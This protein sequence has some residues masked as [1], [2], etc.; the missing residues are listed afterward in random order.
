MKRIIGHLIIAAVL[1][2]AGATA[3]AQEAQTPTAPQPAQKPAE[4]ERVTQPDR[5]V[6]PLSNPAKPAK[7]EASVMRGS[8]TVKGYEGKEVIAEA[9][10][11]EKAIG[12]PDDLAYAYAYA[13]PGKKK[14]VASPKDVEEMQKELQAA[15]MDVEQ[16]KKDA[17]KNMALAKLA[18]PYPPGQEEKKERSH[19]GMKLVTAALT[20]L[21][22]EENNNTVTVS[23]ESMM[24]AVDLTIQVPYSSSVSLGSSMGGKIVVENVSG[25]I[26]INSTNGSVTLRN[27]SGNAVVHTMNGDIEAVL[28]K[29]SADKPLSFSNMNGDIDVTL[30]ADIKAN[31]KM[32]SQMGNIYSDFD[33]TLKPTSKKV[34]SSEEAEKGKYRISFDRAIY[35]IINGG[36]QEI[37][38][39]TFRGDIFI[40]K[41]K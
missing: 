29:V 7:L 15:Q 40:R 17:Q 11:R 32:K 6:V 39:T 10:I 9:R 37:T 5:A 41:K 30:P 35:G 18:T 34:E 27:V 36:G 20:G 16:F 23:T 14:V 28:S 1:L 26:E 12:Q 24:N 13:G 38:L 21:T 8:I 19:D 4:P 3:I 2:A 33:V 31:V 22:V 25:E